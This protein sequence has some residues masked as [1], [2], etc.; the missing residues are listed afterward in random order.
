[1]W[2]WNATWHLDTRHTYTH[3]HTHAHTWA[4]HVVAFV[5][6]PSS[7]RAIHLL[8]L[9]HVRSPDIGQPVCRRSLILQHSLLFLLRLRLL[10]YGSST[11]MSTDV[12]GNL[13]PPV[14]NIYKNHAQTVQMNT[15]LFRIQVSAINNYL[16]DFWIQ[17]KTVSHMDHIFGEICC[18]ILQGRSVRICL[19]WSE[20]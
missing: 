13:L 15:F 20:V 2:Q 4:A 11:G 6:L 1:M 16:Q 3:T 10:T 19:P 8:Q 14:S 12:S 17:V 18:L 9:Q 5:P 7:P